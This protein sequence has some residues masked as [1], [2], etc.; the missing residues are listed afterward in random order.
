VIL[1]ARGCPS[2]TL[3]GDLQMAMAMMMM[4]SRQLVGTGRETRLCA[5]FEAAAPAPPRGSWP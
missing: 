4:G 2:P 5:V 1:A 3:D